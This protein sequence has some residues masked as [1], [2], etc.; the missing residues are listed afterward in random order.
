MKKRLSTK[1]ISLSVLMFVL[2][3]ILLFAM[4]FLLLEVNYGVDVIGYITKNYNRVL[5]V[6]SSVI[7]LSM[8]MYAYYYFECTEI[9]RDMS[10][11]IECF[12]LL[13]LSL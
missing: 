4:I 9:L 8:L 5:F 13:D 10:K 1:T 11:I 12:V 2:N 7:I 6:A 3:I